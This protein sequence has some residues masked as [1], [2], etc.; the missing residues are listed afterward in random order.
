L[1]VCL[2]KKQ[3]VLSCI[4]LFLLVSLAAVPVLAATL[5]PAVASCPSTCSCLLPAEA[6]KM[7][8]PGLCGGKQ[9]ICG[10]DGKISKYCYT[11]PA[12]VTTTTALPQLIVT[13]FHP[14]LTTTT[15]TPVFVKCSVGCECLWE[16]W[17][18]DW[19]R[20]LCGGRESLCGMDHN[21]VKQY[22]YVTPPSPTGSPV[23]ITMTQGVL[24]V[25]PT[26]TI[27]VSAIRP[28]IPTTPKTPVIN[29]IQY[30]APVSCPGGCAC[31]LPADA[32]KRGL[33][34]CGGT[35][36][37]CS[38]SA[39][40]AAAGTGT[41]AETR[42]CYAIPAVQ[43]AITNTSRVAVLN[44][45]AASPLTVTK[46]CPAGCSCL[47]A[48][49]I[50]DKGYADC[51]AEKT[52]CGR[53]ASG[54][55]LYC[56]RTGSGSEIARPSGDIFSAIGS[57]FG[58]LFGRTTTPVT[59]VQG[60]SVLSSYC[61]DRYGP[62]YR[63]CNGACVNTMSDEDNCGGCGNWCNS[64]PGYNPAI[65]SAFTC[66]QG[67]CIPTSEVPGA[68]G[69]YRCGT[70]GDIECPAGTPCLNGVCSS[71]G[72]LDP[73]LTACNNICI[74]TDEDESNCGACGVA[75]LLPN[76]TCR[77][78]SCYT[79]CGEPDTGYCRNFVDSARYCAELDSDMFNCGRCQHTCPS[80]Q[81]CSRGEC[82]SECP[83]D[84]TSCMGGC[85]DT[86]T[87][88]WN[89]GACGNRCD[90]DPGGDW[91]ERCINGECRNPDLAYLPPVR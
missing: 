29:A 83:A 87:S 13:G 43:A 19:N 64:D 85:V 30:T 2:V 21:G 80:S 33:S 84:L 20:T 34:Y 86:M 79:E 81:L 71:L 11:R 47:D 16:P 32:S 57:F 56:A 73:E 60:S 27:P 51:S 59:A 58:F 31:L 23:G 28:V 72:C 69:T 46:A 66:Y 39:V 49:T 36:S 18:K 61:E 75:C 38:I 26:T 10:S 89:C 54:G 82:V 50:R 4:C 90:R 6:A 24:P 67:Q 65:G 5:S 63:L 68:G 52:E 40:I 88:E 62:G 41:T 15:P 8:T 3:I 7:N 25:V 70:G 37:A 42:Y 14:V 74:R 91:R 22:C 76:Q 55:T 1:V 45:S 9:T 53:E 78:G 35:Q 77:A 44:R 12:T 48:Q 17:G